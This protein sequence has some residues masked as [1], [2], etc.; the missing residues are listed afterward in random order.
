MVIPRLP[1]R[2]WSEPPQEVARIPTTD[3]ERVVNSVAL[4]QIPQFQKEN[5]ILWFALIEAAM[6]VS[7]V[8]NDVTKYFYVVSLLDSPTANLIA[9]IIKSPVEK[10][11]TVKE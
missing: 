7:R 1:T 10:F 4:Q 11:Q 5:P 3:E 9:D 6:H 2:T 8:T